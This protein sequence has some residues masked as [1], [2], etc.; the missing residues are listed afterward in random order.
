MQDTSQLL[1]E[2]GITYIPPIQ[3]Q[4]SP[5]KRALQKKFFEE[6]ENR[7]RTEEAIRKWIGPEKYDKAKEQAARERIQ[8]ARSADATQQITNHNPTIDNTIQLAAKQLATHQQ[9]QQQQDAN[10]AKEQISALTKRL[11]AMECKQQRTTTRKRIH[12]H[13]IDDDDDSSEETSSS[14]SSL[15]WYDDDQTHRHNH[16]S[17]MHLTEEKQGYSSE[18]ELVQDQQKRLKFNLDFKKALEDTY[19]K[20]SDRKQS[21]LHNITNLLQQV[22]RKTVDTITK[23]EIIA[24][25][26][27]A[28]LTTIMRNSKEGA[29]VDHVLTAIQSRLRTQQ[30]KWKPLK[31]K[32]NNKKGKLLIAND[33]IQTTLQ[34]LRTKTDDRQID[35]E[36]LSIELPS[37]HADLEAMIRKA[38]NL[39]HIYTAKPATLE[40][41][42]QT[43]IIPAHNTDRRKAL[44]KEQKMR[45]YI[46]K[47]DR[48][49]TKKGMTI[50]KLL[51][52]AQD[53]LEKIQERQAI[54]LQQQ[55]FQRLTY[56]NTNEEGKRQIAETL[57][58]NTTNYDQTV[59]QATNILKG[60]TERKRPDH[61]LLQD[62]SLTAPYTQKTE[63]M[64]YMGQIKGKGKERYE[65]KGKGKGEGEEKGK[66]KGKGKGG[67]KGGTKGDHERGKGEHERGKGEHEKG[68]QGKGYWN[69]G[70]WNTQNSNNWNTQNDWQ[71]RDRWNNGWHE[72]NHKGWQERQ[73]QGEKKETGE[74]KINLLAQPKTGNIQDLR[75]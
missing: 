37:T 50:Q 33:L 9:Q 27:V 14:N 7:R 61:R 32:R 34:E 47:M 19:A 30:R 51:R 15:D 38:T 18:E 10:D 72:S 2:E 8:R 52:R 59:V 56:D 5:E 57:L 67:K 4:P 36:I 58:K 69:Q 74:E 64:S 71:T 44:L 40:A 31:R 45:E 63:R 70:N 26:F 1:R 3:R 17:I 73:Q 28:I 22:A 48:L 54:A 62:L 75:K 35:K 12:T 21:V 43:T 39:Y 66:G 24:D 60:E 55:Q 16:D 25:T 20:R 23:R 49:V 68:S 11:E 65:E 53:T 41:I 46:D 13:R 42:Q 6:L 29:I